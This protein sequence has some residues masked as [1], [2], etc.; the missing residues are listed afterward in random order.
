MFKIGCPLAIACIRKLA[1]R[2]LN[3]SIKAAPLHTLILI[4]ALLPAAAMSQV[5]RPAP[6]NQAPANPVPVNP[7]TGTAAAQLTRARD[8]IQ[9]NRFDEAIALLRSVELQ[10]P[11][12]KGTSHELG[13]AYYKKGEYVSA[14]AAFQ[15]ALVQ[16]PADRESIQLLGLSYFHTGSPAQAIPLLEQVHSW[17]PNANVDAVYV[18]GN[19]YILTKDYPAAR[20]SFAEMFN[21]F[22][23][24]AA[25]YLFLA[26]ML[27][28][29]GF[30]PIAEEHA[31][32]AVALDPRLP[33]AHY[34]LGEFYL[35]KSNIPEAIAQFKKEL[36][37][38]P[39][40]A[41]TY[42]RL[43]DA[44]FRISNLDESQRLLQRSIA[45]DANSTGPYI[46]MGKVLIKKGEPDLA[47]MYLDRSAKMDPNNFITHHLL[48]QAFRSLGKTEDS[49]RELKLA[50]QLQTAQNPK[51]Q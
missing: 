30:D 27:L 29:Q 17:Y 7:R 39:S 11:T 49:Q 24:S 40:Y 50:E 10:E 16:D 4:L 2:D 19:C 28:R 6:A 38:N 51:L 18:L 21:V 31:Q 26:R 46:L 32:K 36:D 45:L 43:A 20:R 12:L 3:F 48:G 35:Y 47:V 15:R 9:N 44:Y 23:D 1:Q 13:I 34:L 42:D 14:I 5:V 22:P 37:L 41:G 33:L 25:S 8:A